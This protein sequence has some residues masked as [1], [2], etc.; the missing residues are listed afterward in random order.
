[1]LVDFK[2][3]LQR[4]IRFLSIL[5][6]IVFRDPASRCKIKYKAPESA[7]SSGSSTSIQNEIYFSQSWYFITNTMPW[8]DQLADILRSLPTDQRAAFLAGPALYPPAGVESVF[9]D[10]PNQNSMVRGVFI[11]YLTLTFAAVVLRGYCKICLVRKVLLED[12]KIG[13]QQEDHGLVWRC[14]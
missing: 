7:S 6:H 10:P 4:Q 11:V 9:D 3:G 1:M 14:Y 5:L 13:P 8:T 2:T 12:C